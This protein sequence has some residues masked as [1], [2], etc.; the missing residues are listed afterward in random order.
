MANLVV[1]LKKCLYDGHYYFRNDTMN[2][3]LK[4]IGFATVSL[5][6]SVSW[7]AVNPADPIP[8][9]PQVKVGKLENG[10]TYYVQHNVL[11]RN[12]AELRLVV[13]A[14]SMQED[15]DQKGL[16]H[17]VEHMAFNGSTH[18]KKH[19]LISYL[20]SIGLKFG[21]DLNAYT[22]FN[23]TVYILPVP[24]KNKA[25][26]EKAFTVLQDWAGGLSLRD[27]D[28][29]M[30]RGIILEELRLGKGPQ[31]RITKMVFP[32]LF[33]DSKYANRLP[34]GNEVLLKTFDPKSLRRFYQEWYRPELMAVV[35]VG[36][37]DEKET[38]DLIRNTFSTLRNPIPSR[39]KEPP[40]IPPRKK[41]DVLI[42]TDKE[43]TGNSVEIMYPSIPDIEPSTIEGYRRELVEG[44]FGQML[45]MRVAELSQQS[46][47]PFI[48]GSSGISKGM[49]GYKAFSASAVIGRQGL[50]SAMMALLAEQERVRK[51][52]FTQI[53]LDRVKKSYLSS[54]EKSYLEREK[55]ESTTYAAEYI[56]NFL[57]NEPLP[58]IVNEYSY[59]QEFVPK[60]PLDEINKIAR[61][62]IPLATE[63]KLIVYTG[64]QEKNTTPA[65][66]KILQSIKTAE[67][68]VVLPVVQREVPNE[69]L[70]VKPKPGEIVFERSNT[71]LGLTELTFG[72]GVKA[73]LKPSEFKEDQVVM[74]AVRFGG[75]SLYTE[76]DKYNAAY[77]STVAGV[78]GVG[79]YTLTDI[80]KILSGKNANVSTSLGFYTENISGS[81]GKNDIETMLQL[82][83]MK[84]RP[85]RKD[86]ALFNS[87]IVRSQDASK[88]AAARP[89]TT[90]S[91]ARAQLMYN[92]HPRVMLTPVSSD[93][94]K[95][96]MERAIEIYNERF[97]S[98][99]DMT[100]LFAGSFTIDTIKPLL[101]TYIAS[102]PTNDIPTTFKDI[103]LRPVKG[104]IQK[105][106]KHGE[107]PKSRVSMSFTGDA[108]FSEKNQLILTTLTEVMNI[109]IIDVLRE[110][111]A[112]IYSGGMGG[113]ISKTPVESYEIGIG[114][115]C[116]PENVNNVRQTMLS[117]LERMKKTGP[118][119]EEM[120]KV[121]TNWYDTFDKYQGS[122]DY[123]I[124]RLQTHALYNTDYLELAK[125]RSLMDEVTAKD[126]Q[127]AAKK[128]FNTSNYMDLVFSPSKK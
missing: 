37:I 11:P 51:F 58:G 3:V 41:T 116:A 12:R 106:I 56:R 120:L 107:E 23:E 91:D 31:D 2:V 74:S 1:V 125:S 46:E 93:F 89:E 95:I 43:V 118:T 47:P 13:K 80:A 65:P 124:A 15:E 25:D 35:A 109:R 102:L 79:D 111:K 27:E 50:D 92:N 20:Q 103:G 53:E 38:I 7:G 39:A 60:V 94:D 123:W 42:I 8:M 26:V 34:I 70:K 113:S 84:M 78:M 117:E 81:S 14:G 36:D 115:P 19:E 101:L 63:P 17:F 6:T 33:K 45:G 67:T 112:L 110:Q 76:D 30:E 127:D 49:P 4:W 100:F 55:T 128:Y 9:G 108:Q 24:T 126:V 18:F 57:V 83:T 73:L 104:V 48:A 59:F 121:K 97:T 62:R 10:L 82:L 122:N 88:Y 99:K 21:A 72:N 5:I 61:A 28:I 87:F 90:F 16:A 96:S 71:Y 114:L 105:E 68:Q 22:S 44:M 86:P 54:I 40:T 52:G 75:Q 85:A 119:Q 64:V 98:A 66:A 32:K 77:A 69:L 29:N